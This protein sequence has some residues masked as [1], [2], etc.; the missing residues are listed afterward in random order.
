MNSALFSI[1]YFYFFIK[2][3]LIYS[4]VTIYI[5]I[6]FFMAAPRAYGSSWA[7]DGIQASAVTQATAVAM[8]DPL[9]HCTGSGI[10]PVPPQ[11]RAVGF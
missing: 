9:T 10:E 8:P 5:Y 3:E 11:A 4:I 7:R 2:V 6:L 1:F